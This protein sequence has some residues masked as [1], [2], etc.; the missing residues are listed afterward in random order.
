MG[1]RYD[2]AVLERVS[3]RQRSDMWRLACDDAIEE[4]GIVEEWFGPIQVTV[5]EAMPDW[6]ALNLVLG[7]AEP[8]AIEEGHLTAAIRW[9]DSFEVDYRVVVAHDRPGTVTAETWLNWNGFEQRRGQLRFVRNASPVDLAPSEDLTVWEIGQEDWHGETMVD[10]AAEA[11][12]LP[13]PASHLLFS[14]PVQRHW[15]TYTVE[16][17]GEIVSFGSML[18]KDRVALLGLDATFERYRGRGCNT[19]LLGRRVQDAIEAGCETLFAELEESE[20]EE[21]AA[22]A[23]NLVRAGFVPCCRSVSWQRPL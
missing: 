12:K 21:I 5:F 23:R 14:L 10:G 15:R 1:V 4:C 19:A 9:A 3:K 20:A 17:E 8:G 2:A 22:A 11:M 13:H 6:P 7:A 16:T 18:L